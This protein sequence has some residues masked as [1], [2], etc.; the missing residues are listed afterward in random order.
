MTKAAIT[1]MTQCLPSLWV[2]SKDIGNFN[3]SSHQLHSSYNKIARR[4]SHKSGNTNNYFIKRKFPTNRPVNTLK[5]LKH[6][7]LELSMLHY[8]TNWRRKTKQKDHKIYVLLK[9]G[10]NFLLDFF[11]P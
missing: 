8:K 2:F 1:V 11:S 5:D 6:N 10:E 9:R 3:P 7:F 4:E